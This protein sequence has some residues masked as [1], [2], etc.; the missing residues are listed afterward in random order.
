MVPA[1]SANIPGHGPAREG[2]AYQV[3]LIDLEFLW[4]LHPP[5]A[6]TPFLCICTC[7]S[8]SPC[9]SGWILVKDPKLVPRRPG[10]AG[11]PLSSCHPLCQ[12]HLQESGTWGFFQVPSLESLICN[13]LNIFLIQ[14]YTS[15]GYFP[16]WEDCNTK[17]STGSR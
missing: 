7:G 16:L 3:R 4:G 9:D 15:N 8:P 12:P 6:T 1:P 10:E 5:P 2:L 11:G 17:L 13:N 14:K